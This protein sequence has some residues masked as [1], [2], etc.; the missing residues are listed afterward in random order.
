MPGPVEHRIRQ[1]SPAALARYAR[2]L[3]PTQELEPVPGWSFDRPLRDDRRRTRWRRLIWERYRD[4][5]LDRPVEIGWCLGLRVSLR[6]G[7]DTSWSV[8]VDGAYEP[9]ELAFLADTLRPGMTVIDVGANEGLYTLAAARLVRDSGL[10]VAVEPSTRE[11]AVLERNIRLNRLQNVQVV[12]AAL[13]EHEGSGWLTRA[14]RGH[15]GQNTL[16][17]RIPNPGVTAAGTE[18]VTVTTLD[19]VAAPLDQVDL[20]KVDAE[21]CEAHILRGATETLR[22]HRPTL[23]LEV[24]PDHLAAQGS[25]GPELLQLLDGYRVFVLDRDGTPRPHTGEPLRLGT[26]LAVPHTGMAA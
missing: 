6:M 12:R 18:T 15:E 8:F 4:E 21:G 14:G 17:G 11:V 9:N 7:N 3:A 24:A 23:I 1:A 13:H 22:R 26:I 10:V 5:R 20:V 25:S 19:T 2:L 16:G